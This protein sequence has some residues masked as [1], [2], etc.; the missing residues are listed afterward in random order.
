MVKA[1]KFDVLPISMLAHEQTDEDL[2]YAIMC[3]EVIAFETLYNRYA[4]VVYSLILEL[5]RHHPLAEEQLQ[6]TFCQVWYKAESYRGSGSVAAW[7]LQIARNRA[8][9]LLRRQ[10][11]RRAQYLW[12]VEDTVALSTLY[13]CFDQRE[14][15]QALATL[16][17]EQ[18]ICLELSYFDGLSQREIAQQLNVALG[19]IKSRTRLALEKLEYLLR[20][21]GYP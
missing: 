21:Q 10:K 5:V 3:K 6:E 11:V 20:M 8:L 14:V 4:Q 12:Q 13:D 17:E 19:T 2:L 1:P 7:L 9:D 18:R 15:C 16:P